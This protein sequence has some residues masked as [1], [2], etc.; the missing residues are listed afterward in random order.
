MDP[1]RR[2]LESLSA[3]TD[4]EALGQRCLSSWEMHR[5]TIDDRSLGDGSS[6]L[7]EPPFSLADFISRVPDNRT[8]TSFSSLIKNS[9]SADE[10]QT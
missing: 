8:T 9:F 3:D 5:T 1:E 2:A 6:Y 7:G 4:L 10:L